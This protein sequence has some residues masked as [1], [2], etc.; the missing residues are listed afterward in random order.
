VAYA[1]A[2][3]RTQDFTM[4]GV[5]IGGFRNFQKGA[6]P[7][8]LGT[9]APRWSQGAKPWYEVWGRSNPEAESKCEINAQ[10]LTF[11]R[12]KLRIY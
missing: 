11:S 6:E 5:H 1:Q 3:R 10:F 9:E 2:Y 4:E 8:G 12:R 7:G